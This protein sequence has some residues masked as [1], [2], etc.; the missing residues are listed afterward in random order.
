M[1]LLVCYLS[2][3]R[4]GDTVVEWVFS[5]KDMHSFHN[6]MVSSFF[7]AWERKYICMDTST[8]PQHAMAFPVKQ[9]LASFFFFSLQLI[10]ENKSKEAHCI[11]Q[12][13]AESGK[14]QEVAAPVSH[15]TSAAVGS[16]WGEWLTCLLSMI[17][18]VSSLFHWRSSASKCK[19]TSHRK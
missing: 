2:I 11:H 3:W 6:T 19:L 7:S 12:S 18:E 16:S 10:W 9:G 1:L 4:L 13:R 17:Q 8:L 14:L 15:T 5:D